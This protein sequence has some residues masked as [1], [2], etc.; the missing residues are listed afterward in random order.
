MGRLNRSFSSDLKTQEWNPRRRMGLASLTMRGSVKT[1]TVRIHWLLAAMLALLAAGCSHDE[2]GIASE[3]A[4]TLTVTSTAFAE[5]QAIPD[6]Y[7][8]HGDD[9]S[10]PLQ[11]SGAP[12]ETK[13]FAIICEDPDAPMGTW[14][15]WVIFNIPATATG[16][17]E[18]VAK[19]GSLPDGSKQ[20]KNSF[21]N[22]GYNGPAPPSGQKHRYFF[23]VFALDTTLTLDAGADRHNVA[24]AM[25]G[26][27]LARG[28]LMGTYQSQ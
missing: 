15:H 27:I 5:G 19:I 9:V 11:W 4:T 16:L 12:S 26:H 1:M 6:K 3:G 24:N 13:S 28:H 14:T 20:T 7:T 2:A 8:G 18:N 23:M 10:P 25:D 21:G 17:P 22:I